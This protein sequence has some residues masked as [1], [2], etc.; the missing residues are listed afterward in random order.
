MYKRPVRVLFVHPRDDF[1]ARQAAQW[2]RDLGGE[3]LES[4][5][6]S[7]SGE[8]CKKREAWPDLVI[9]LDSPPIHGPTWT[10]R[11]QCRT[12]P[13]DAGGDWESGVRE[14]IRGI[15]GGLK[16]LARLDQSHAPRRPTAPD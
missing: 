7:A 1:R 13:A 6:I 14:K 11:T 16:L 8:A 9:Y 2:A 12:W 15:L 4:D 10:G 5:G 3:W